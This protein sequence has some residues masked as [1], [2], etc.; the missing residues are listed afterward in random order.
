MLQLAFVAA[1]VPLTPHLARLIYGSSERL[2]VILLVLLGS[3]LYLTHY[4]LFINLLYLKRYKEATLATGVAVMVT[5][6]ALLLPPDA[7]ALLGVPFALGSISGIVVG[8]VLFRRAAKM[9][10]RQIL[11]DR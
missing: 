7:E 11:T 10:D 8:A 9:I 2:V 4:T 5:L 3:A 6:L 1:L